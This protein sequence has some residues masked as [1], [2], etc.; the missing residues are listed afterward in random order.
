MLKFIFKVIGTF[1]PKKKLI[2]KPYPS[3]LFDI[4]PNS[5]I[6]LIAGNGPFPLLF[7]ERAKALGHEVHAVCHENET[8]K[9]LEKYC[10][11]CI[12]IKV[13]EL[14]R[15][16]D[17]FKNSKVS[18]G[19]MA[20]GISRIKH[21]GDIKLD[22][23]GTMLIMRLQSTK[24][25]VI[26][27]GIASEIEDLGIKVIPCTALFEDMIT[28]EGSILGGGLTKEEQEDVNVGVRAIK[29]MS[30][31]DIG[32]LVVVREGVVVA[33]EAVE[34]TNETIK[35]SG[36]LGRNNLV[37]V[38]CAKPTQ[39]MRFDV[40]TAG[41][42]TIRVCKESGVSVLALEAGRSIIIDKENFL[43]NAKQ[44][45]LKVIGIPPII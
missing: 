36:T 16:L 22:L 42:E 38:K 19:M 41:V 30:G 18:F 23:K 24:D 8:D 10:K 12:W 1:L 3:L 5:S 2:S 40:P 26:M 17:Y 37:V 39:D 25:D 6:G 33:V 28:E 7:A 13:G 27:R 43:K 31:E 32:Q 34:G 35:R 4:P 20:G 29:A 44:I 21:F 45:G 15:I 9:E 14:G 11:S